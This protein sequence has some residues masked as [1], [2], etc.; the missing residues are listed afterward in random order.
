MLR[1]IR[2][3]LV[4]LVLLLS[5]SA[6]SANGTQEKAKKSK[7]KAWEKSAQLGEYRPAEDDWAAIE[8]AAKK[9]GDVVVYS[10]SSRVT[11]FCRSFTKRYGI[12]AEGNSFKTPNLIE[13]LRREQDAGVYN[14]DVVMT[15]NA[16]QFVT[17]FARTGRVYKFIP[18]D[19]YPLL[20]ASAKK[21][22]LAIAHYGAKVVMYNTETYKKPPIDSWW[23]LTRPEWKGRLVTV[24]PLKSGTEFNLFALFIRHSDE[25]AKLYKEEFGEDIVL[26]GTE[27]AG[28]EF[29]KRLI[30]NGLVLF[31]GGNDVAKAIGAKGQANPP[32]GIN[33]YSKLR[34]AAENNLA[35]GVITNLKPTAGISTKSVLSIPEF[36]KHPNAAKLMIRWMMGGIN[37]KGLAGYAPYHVMGDWSP[38]TD[39]KQPKG[40][41]PLDKM[42]L[43]PE[44]INWLYTNRVK[45]RDFWIQHM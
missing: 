17:E 8:K 13:K 43:W 42:N 15:G 2:F 33:S 6:L 36:A 28:Y 40:Q 30:E 21:E 3:V 18:T 35:L 31:S 44:D 9:E 5:V 26:H 27:N 16:T 23:D 20:T 4:A 19:I 39:I 24:D 7:V 38:R 37:E 32:I 12:K 11:K 34:K 25:M 14:A 1:K 41:P 22:P 10:N 45:V 29:L